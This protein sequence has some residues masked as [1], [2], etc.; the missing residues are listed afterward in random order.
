MAVN[1]GE[2][3]DQSAP[4]KPMA[5]VD[6]PTPSGNK[7]GDLMDQEA[8]A[9]SAALKES[10]YVATTK[11]PDA[12]A[13]A[14]ALSK[15]TGVPA[16][17]IDQD[18]LP[19]VEA[20]AAKNGT[21]HTQ[22]M[23]SN[24]RVG[25]FLSN[26]DHAA[27]THDDVPAMK[28]LEDDISDFSIGRS[29]LYAFNK[30]GYHALAG[31][32]KIP[33]LAYDVA[34][35]PQNLYGK[36]ADKPNWIVHAP[37]WAYNNPVS[38]WATETANK[39]EQ[40]NMPQSVV[41]ELGKGNPKRAGLALA[42]GISQ[43][44]P[45]TIALLLTGVAG[46]ARQGLAMAGAS[47][48]ADKASQ[49]LAV[50]PGEPGYESASDPLTRTGN[51]LVHGGLEAATESLG[52]LGL[53][54]TWAGA[55]SKS[56]GKQT[57]IEVFKD[58]G[59]AI[60]H[61]G[62]GEGMEE[63]INS[64]AQDVNDWATGVTPDFDFMD[65]LKKSAD[66]FIIG[67]GSGTSMTGPVAIAQGVKRMTEERT[68]QHASEFYISVGEQLDQTKVN[69]RSADVKTSMVQELTA[70]TDAEHV[71]I[72]PKD[73]TTY[74]QGKNE[75]P[76]KAAQDLGLSKE[77]D[78]AVESGVDLKVP[79][80]VW[81]KAFH[82]TDHYVG[83]SKDIKF[84]PEQQ[85]LNELKNSEEQ[86]QSEMKAADEKAQAEADAEPKY[87]VVGPMKEQLLATGRFSDQEAKLAAEHHARFLEGISRVSAIPVEDLIKR[88]PLKIEDGRALL[89]NTDPDAMILEQAKVI[90][91][92]FGKKPVAEGGLY[93]PSK[94]LVSQ[95]S[96]EDV[97]KLLRGDFGQDVVDKELK[98]DNQKLVEKQTKFLGK[99]IVEKLSDHG[100]QMLSN[101]NARVS[102]D[103]ENGKTITAAIKSAQNPSAPPYVDSPDITAIRWSPNY[104]AEPTGTIG[105]PQIQEPNPKG[106][107]P[108]PMMW[109]EDKYKATKEL[110]LK[111]KAAGIP[112]TINTS[113]DLIAREGYIDILPPGTTVNLYMLTRDD[114]I[115]KVLF[116]GNPSNLRLENAA[117]RLKEAGIN[118]NVIRPTV[119]SVIS[120]ANK[121]KI[122]KYFSTS[123]KEA[124]KLIDK[125]L[126]LRVLNQDEAPIS[127]EQINKFITELVEKE[128]DTDDAVARYKKLKA[129]EGGKFISTDEARDLS[130]LYVKDPEAYL[131]YTHAVAREIAWSAFLDRLSVPAKS[132]TE[133]VM[134]LAGGTGSGK[135][136]VAKSEHLAEKYEDA[137]AIYD[138]TL[139]AYTDAK[140]R[141][142]HSLNTGR[143]VR[144]SFV[145]T[146]IDNAI[147]RIIERFNRTKRYVP[148]E[149]IVSSHMKSI[150]T[151]IKLYDEFH[152]D[153]NFHFDIID[154][155][156]DATKGE[157]P[158]VIGIEDLRKAVYTESASEI[159]DRTKKGLADVIKSYESANEKVR[160]EAQS[161]LQ[162]RAQS[163]SGTNRGMESQR[164]RDVREDGQE[165]GESAGELAQKESLSQDD[166]DQPYG[167]RGQISFGTD[168]K[169][170][171]DF[172]KSADL[173][174]AIHEL[175]HFHFEVL[176]RL[177]QDEKSNATVKEDY[178]KILKWLGVESK[179][180]ITTISWR[181]KLPLRSSGRHLR[182][183]RR[184]CSTF[185]ATSEI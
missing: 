5:P 135:S 44:A 96:V 167:P 29:L 72:N 51:A 82:G 160:A 2:L 34:A 19:D 173:S 69:K 84:D 57:A 125:A 67:L 159:L 171:I 37:D 85:S 94:D 8:S 54:K 50:K 164:G 71:Y 20:A 101:Y 91:A 143:K 30:G 70:G 52:T 12:H 41:E 38:N 92:E 149:A 158:K 80:S 11:N 75:S 169:F 138:S 45:Q 98:A 49:L 108:D 24:P 133:T 116:P 130:A 140:E 55:I 161:E 61:S 14:L 56:Y 154:N 115:N 27:V 117:Q 131:R 7:Y 128:L 60:G 172:F 4:V 33:A 156:G 58:F 104:L 126:G 139:T 184:G 83:L 103:D 177:A 166:N 89:E 153:P 68:A 122:S 110:I 16:D 17:L 100:K 136:T 170:K 141:I 73:F 6:A 32:A 162:K 123:K 40:A 132:P 93:E 74:F 62:L 79:M 124:A 76:A 127:T 145:Y 181:A 36:L 144:I 114:N 119:E 134:L 25:T 53:L 48:G 9:K 39:F 121:E 81:T 47:S 90:H 180:Q 183:S 174:T 46:V 111:H 137:H 22:I 15:K 176:G 106:A 88:F 59:K 65:S 99:K 148:A 86:H 102:R 179:D 87:D 147:P 63:S 23:Q 78:E 109:A 113:S 175:S 42:A 112:L 165:H 163:D 43:A 150:E 155:N 18:T 77:Y 97:A 152:G 185:I 157:K 118:V 21:D 151:M 1:Y 10:M 120:V 107:H 13:Q 3:M 168:D 31:V 182:D 178:A 129:A 64:F 142:D 95:V 66:A 146:H 28:K 105:Q 35:I 26:K